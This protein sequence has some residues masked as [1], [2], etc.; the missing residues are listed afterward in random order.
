[1]AAS[2]RWCR[3]VEKSSDDLSWKELAKVLGI[4]K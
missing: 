2:G 4:S 1:M 3:F